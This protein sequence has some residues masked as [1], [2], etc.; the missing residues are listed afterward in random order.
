[1]MYDLYVQL[2][3]FLQKT[4]VLFEEGKG[5]A[6]SFV[7]LWGTNLVLAGGEREIYSPINSGHAV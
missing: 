3:K 5:Q 6:T 7:P 2:I 1:M 4:G